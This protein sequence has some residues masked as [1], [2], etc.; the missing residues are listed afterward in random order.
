MIWPTL[1]A[2]EISSLARN[3]GTQLAH[4]YSIELRIFRLIEQ[5]MDDRP[6]IVSILSE[7]EDVPTP[8]RKMDASQRE[9]SIL[10]C[11][12]G[13][14]EKPI[15]QLTCNEGRTTCSLSC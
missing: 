12:A 10:I 2:I 1:R 3:R 8:L 6:P 13:L 4:S 11:T 9:H 7:Q 15:L 14:R 5:K